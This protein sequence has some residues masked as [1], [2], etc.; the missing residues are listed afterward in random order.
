M[1]LAE[2]N[3]WWKIVGPR[4]SLILECRWERRINIF[5]FVN[6][7]TCNCMGDLF[8]F[9]LLPK[10]KGIYRKDYAK[11]SDVGGEEDNDIDA[12]VLTHAYV[13]HCA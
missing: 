13:D 8:E 7:R 2:T 4:Y 5:E 11:H 9:E 10:L 6:P 12:I 1:K 3:F